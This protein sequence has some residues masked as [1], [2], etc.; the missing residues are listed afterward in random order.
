[1]RS[2]TALQLTSAAERQSLFSHLSI[3]VLTPNSHVFVM[4]DQGVRQLRILRV[5]TESRGILGDLIHN[6]TDISYT[7]SDGS[8]R[9]ATQVFATK[10]DLIAS[11]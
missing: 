2:S 10:Q 7:L 9:P 1:M 8:C 6:E 3:E 4:T 5:H 11:L